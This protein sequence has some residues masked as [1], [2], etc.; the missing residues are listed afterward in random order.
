V[1]VRVGAVYTVAARRVEP[2]TKGGLGGGMK[3]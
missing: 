1:V 3:V 2:P